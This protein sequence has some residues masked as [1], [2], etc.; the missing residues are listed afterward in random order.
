MSAQ[1][2]RVEEKLFQNRYL[3]DSGRPHITIAPH[4]KPSKNLLSMTKLCPA[5]C[6]EENS[7][8][9]VEITPDGC[10]EC[11]TCRV[12]CEASGDIVWNY[13]RGGYGVLFKF[14]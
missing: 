1:I 12:L 13:P 5:G 6:Y 10:L 4:S 9:Q 3:V 14:G 7:A 11:G 8:G 2:A